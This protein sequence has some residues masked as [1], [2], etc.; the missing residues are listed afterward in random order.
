MNQIKIITV[1]FVV[2]FFIGSYLFYLFASLD[3]LKYYKLFN[4]IGLFLN[5]C[6][7]LLLSKIV[8]NFSKKQEK[9]LDFLYFF[10]YVGI[11]CIPLGMLLGAIFLS[12]LTLP[13]SGIASKFAGGL[14][15]Y[16]AAPL[17][18][19][20]YSVEIFKL[21]FYKSVSKRVTFMGWYIL[22]AGM[23]LQFTG[24]ILDLIG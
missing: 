8:I 5:I 21:D 11:H 10:L 20:D 12:W 3:S 19:A 14:F 4:T 2:Q 18:I 9:L 1:T 15:S 17:F 22:L 16:V 13:S 23:V 24:S 6:G 7:V